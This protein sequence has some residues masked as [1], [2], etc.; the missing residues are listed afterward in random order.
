MPTPEQQAITDAYLTGHNLVIEA[1]AGTGKTSTLRL[2]ANAAPQRRGIYVAY[3]R[4]IADDAK[5]SFPPNV[6]C[7]TAHSLAFRAIGRAF[8]H[9]LSAPRMPAREVARQLAITR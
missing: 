9:R 7:A 3:N 6:T 2:L 8:D 1:G 4:A 5:R